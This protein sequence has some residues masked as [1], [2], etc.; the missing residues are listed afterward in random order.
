MEL[1]SATTTSDP[2][3]GWEGAMYLDD[4]TRAMRNLARAERDRPTR[5]ERQY[6]AGLKQ[7]REL[8]DRLRGLCEDNKSLC[9]QYR[10]L[11]VRLQQ[12]QREEL[13][14]RQTHPLFTVRR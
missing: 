13:W 7:L 8:V 11:E 6:E 4:L 2:S 12:L 14:M 5:W 10:G 3:Q 1:I 9:N